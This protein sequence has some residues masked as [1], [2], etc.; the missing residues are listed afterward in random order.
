MAEF[1]GVIN[2][3][4]LN[5]VLLAVILLVLRGEAEA[6]YQGHHYQ[7]QQRHLSSHRHHQ[8]NHRNPSQSHFMPASS[9]S[10]RS[11]APA[12]SPYQSQSS[13]R[14]PNLDKFLH[15][16]DPEGGKQQDPY[17]GG[18]TTPSPPLPPPL[19]PPPRGR[20]SSSHLLPAFMRPTGAPSAAYVATARPSVHS[21][22]P[23]PHRHRHQ[24]DYEDYEDE[25]EDED[26]EEDHGRGRHGG[27]RDSKVAWD[28]KLSE[29]ANYQRQQPSTGIG[30]LGTAGGGLGDVGGHRATGTGSS[31]SEFKWDVLGNRTAMDE[32][33]RRR[34]GRLSH[35]D[36]EVQEAVQHNLKVS[37]EGLC[38]VPHPKVVQV[39]DVYPH[40]AKTYLPHCTILH[41]CGDD[42]GCCRHETLSCVPRKTKRIELYFY[43]TTLGSSH[44]SVVEK[45][46]FYNHTECECQDKM[47][48]MMPRDTGKATDVM[49]RHF[50]HSSGG[51]RSENTRR[52]T[53]LT[54]YRPDRTPE[55]PPAW[56]CRCPSLYSVR[57]PP[58]GSS[59]SCSCDCFDKQ[60]ECIR[61]KRGKEYFS[62]PDR[63]CIQSEEC[64][65]PT[66]EFGSYIRRAGRC[67]RKREKFA[68][69]QRYTMDEYK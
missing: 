21:T 56:N 22:A 33:R 40:P 58:S 60:R 36:N 48:E 64:L 8:L 16:L 5:V 62:L 65:P 29:D 55:Q 47:E 52:W 45:L 2:V 18:P 32:M 51:L 20:D 42:T 15:K 69:W 7:H 3:D 10:V 38:K 37:R 24:E 49:V 39:K 26:D 61:A 41:Q 66:C 25:E 68:A 27:Q 17:G 1:R 54:S 28:L 9:A 50:R 13:S 46:V 12:P 57:Y 4:R 6:Y 30:G 53:P 63:L 31:F 11:F 23:P 59:G 44:R 19:P 43:T 35:S 67:P 34:L 14:F